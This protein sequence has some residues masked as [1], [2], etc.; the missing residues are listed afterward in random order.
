[1]AKVAFTTPIMP[2]KG[3]NRY[4]EGFFGFLGFI[5]RTELKALSNAE[6]AG[7][8]VTMGTY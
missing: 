1:M 7:Y 4:F 6:S 2:L 8:L 5:T 3:D